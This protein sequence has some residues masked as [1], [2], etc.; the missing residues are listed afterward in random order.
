LKFD[1]DENVFI[2]GI[3]L[4]ILDQTADEKNVELENGDDKSLY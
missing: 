3:I 2:I 1:I 4:S